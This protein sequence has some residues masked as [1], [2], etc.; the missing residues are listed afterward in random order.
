MFK[1]E[2][3]FKIYKDLIFNKKNGLIIFSKIGIEGT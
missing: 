2:L 1:I 3:V